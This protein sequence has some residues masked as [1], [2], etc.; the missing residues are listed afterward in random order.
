M[1][2]QSRRQAAVRSSTPAH[3]TTA[4]HRMTPAHRMTLARRQTASRSTAW[5]WIASLWI[6]MVLPSVLVCGAATAQEPAGRM[7]VR[8]GGPGDW[9]PAV[10]PPTLEVLGFERNESR[11]IGLVEKA[12]GSFAIEMLPPG[13]YTLRLLGAGSDSVR[14]RAAIHP[15]T[16][17]VVRVDPARGSLTV[18][19]FHPDPFGLDDSWD[20][21][22]LDALPYE[23]EMAAMRATTDPSIPRRA[24]LDGSPLGD[25]GFR[26][27]HR[28]E[29]RAIASAV[30]IPVGP[31]PAS[32]GGATR[33]ILSSAAPVSGSAE[34]AT[35]TGGQSFLDAAGSYRFDHLAWKPSLMAALR[36][37]NELDAAPSPFENDRLPHNGLDGIE[38]L[39]EASAQ[40]R[41]ATRLEAFGYANGTSRDFFLESYRR[42]P[43]HSP[44]E[45]RAVARGELRIEQG[46]GSPHR[47]LASIGVS[48]S[49]AETGDGVYQDHI[50]SYARPPDENAHVEE[51]GLYWTGDDRGTAGDE[52][53]VYDYFRRMLQLDLDARLEAW[54]APGTARARAIGL[55]ARTGTY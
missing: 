24:T 48:R 6:A 36:A 22:W 19:P 3:R 1:R 39:V 15:G 28:I 11:S 40:P 26:S 54:R 34:A 33:S 20:S 10:V 44:S 35:G 29:D 42:D 53:H 9:S 27:P 47:L 32:L 51:D 41:A 49:F 55:F 45:D 43:T 13:L 46:V 4:A 16:T 21:A 5:L 52:G 2:P 12:A 31:A 8:I 50:E 37:R 30:R 38:L 18:E 23:G 17:T 14:V 25:L 7:L